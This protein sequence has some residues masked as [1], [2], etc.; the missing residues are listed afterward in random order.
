MWSVNLTNE[1]NRKLHLCSYSQSCGWLVWQFG[2]LS[3][4]TG[5]KHTDLSGFDRLKWGSVSAR[6]SVG[7]TS[8][9]R[10][11][12]QVKSPLK[13]QNL[14]F[15]IKLDCWKKMKS[16]EVQRQWVWARASEQV[17]LFISQQ[18]ANLLLTNWVLDDLDLCFT[19]HAGS[20]YTGLGICHL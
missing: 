13:I 18:A 3:L 5:Q 12:D 20:G 10:T 19:T 4:N 7:H 9:A 16:P 14:K 6:T 2:Y 1:K 11:K 8:P 17:A 15:C